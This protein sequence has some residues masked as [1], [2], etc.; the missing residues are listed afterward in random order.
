ME[1][2]EQ[3]KHRNL[4]VWQSGMALAKQ[5]YVL[6]KSFPKEERFGLYS[7]MSR[8]AVSIPSNIAEGASRRSAIDF[9]HFLG[10]ARGL[11][12][13]LDTQLELAMSFGFL[14]YDASLQGEVVGLGKQLNALIRKLDAEVGK[15]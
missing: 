1:V 2:T 5:V 14:T 3:F 12:A 15:H 11:L 4:L 10:I 6:I 7:Q 8:T 9:A 13:E